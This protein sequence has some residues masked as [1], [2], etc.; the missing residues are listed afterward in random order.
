MAQRIG[1]LQSIFLNRSSAWLVGAFAASALLLG[2]IGLY[3]VMA[4]SVSRRTREI[5]I[6][7]ALGAERGAI[8][9]LILREAGLVALTGIA[10]GLGCSIAGAALFKHLLFGVESWDAPTLI[11]VTLVLAICAM[12][13]SFLPART[14]ASVNPVE[15]LRAE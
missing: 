5:G 6:R 12:L 4:Y 11:A 7:M 14:A 9:R 3:G 2:A 15:S 8:Y 1:N 13:A 10:A